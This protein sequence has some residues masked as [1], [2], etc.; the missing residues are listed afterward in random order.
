[1]RVV[2]VLLCGCLFSAG[3]SVFAQ[4]I[5]RPEPVNASIPAYPAMA[6]AK[7]ISGVVLVDVRVD[8]EGKVIEA[9]AVLGDQYLRDA[10]VKAALRWRFKALQPEAA[11]SYSVRLTFIFHDF[12]YKPPEKKPDFRSPYQIEILYP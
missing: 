1:M 9:S 4:S 6:R 10:A 8:R 7:R 5:T 11:D 12:S 3:T 2:L